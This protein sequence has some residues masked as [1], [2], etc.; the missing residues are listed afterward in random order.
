MKQTQRRL[1]YSHVILASGFTVLFF[2]SGARMAFGLVLKPM[3][4]DLDLSRSALSSALTI[5][6]VVSAL[7]MPIVGRLIDMYSIRIIIAVGTIVG[8]AAIALMGQINASRQLFVLYGLVFA[9]GHAASSVA[10]VSVLMSR[11][12]P[13]RRGLAASAAISGNGIGQLVIIVL[14][15]SFLES[16]GW[17]TS[18]AILGAVNA[19]VVLPIA[20]VAIKSHPP[21]K[22]A[23]VM[24][25]T[26]DP[27]AAG[28]SLPLW[29]ALRSREF[30]LL[31]ALYAA[32]GAQDFF[33]ATHVVAFAQDQGIS[34]FLAGNILAFMG[35]LGLT[36]VLIS[37]AMSDKMG[38]ARPTVL[39]FILRIGLFAYIPIFQDTASITVF[40][41]L[42]GFTFTMTAPLTVVF[43]SNIFGTSRL[44]TLSGV[45]NMVHQVAGGLGAVLGAVIFDWRGSYDAA[46]VIMLILAVV[47]TVAVI[48]LRERP[49]EY[50]MAPEGSA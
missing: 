17:R 50:R 37:G 10:P 26:F 4:E 18:Y 33:M 41:L 20:L 45:I 5:F 19:V 13:E 2:S 23:V 42:Y 29:A 16:L 25:S 34:Q 12:F 27:E 35:L 3:S 22:P 32:C 47:G 48:A 15:A 46:F 1:D 21:P 40:A 49:F 14:M 39:C 9:V 43:V 8:T 28:R 7:T 36:G 30:L 24:R 31:V 44:G 38:A 11:W 6:M